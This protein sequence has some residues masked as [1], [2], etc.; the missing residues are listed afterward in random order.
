MKTRWWLS[1][2]AVCVLAG[3]AAFFA[4]RGTVAAAPPD[5]LSRWLALSPEQSDNVQKDDPGFSSDLPALAAGARQERQKFSEL[6]EN[7][8]ST[9]EAIRGQLQRVLDADAAL[10]RRV[11]DHVLKVRDHL[12]AAQQEQLMALCAQGFRGGMRRGRMGGGMGPGPGG[13]MG[14]GGPGRGMGRGPWWQQPTSAPS[15]SAPTTGPAGK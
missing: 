8:A 1:I 11:L 5:P 3:A 13:G 4:G 9:D 2:G 6:L 14:R 10:Q 7:P 12:T 15:T